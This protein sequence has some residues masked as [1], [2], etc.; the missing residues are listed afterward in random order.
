MPSK[1]TL[2]RQEARYLCDA[3]YTIQEYRKR[4]ANQLRAAT[5]EHEQ[6]S[7]ILTSFLREYERL[8]R[9]MKTELGRFARSTEIGRWLLSICGIGPVITAGLIAEIDIQKA[10]TAGHIWAFAGLA[11]GVEWNKH[12]KRPWNA[13]LKT[14][15][16]KIGESLVKVSGNDKDVYGKV[17]RQRKALEIE[18]NE[19]G[20]FAEQ[21]SQKLAVTKIGKDTEAYKWYS[22]GKLPP[23]H[24]DMRARR[25]AVKRFLADLQTAWYWLEFHCLP[26]LPYPIAILEHAHYELPSAFD[27]MPDL[28]EAL[29]KCG[30]RS[31]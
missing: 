30:A 16:Y 31:V 22:Q 6:P 3:Y 13:R 28:R 10:V 17:Y 4:A 24:L 14:L 21:A 1:R 23:A 5:P 29:S 26:P 12:E 25:V 7:E 15:C 19:R 18:R 20:E 27:N 2:T 11:P 8:E 9:R